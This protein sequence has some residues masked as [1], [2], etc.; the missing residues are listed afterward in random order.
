[1]I[2]E[3]IQQKRKAAGL[4][5]AQLAELL[6][7]S[8]PAV[9]RWE[10]DLSFPDATLLAP[11]ARCLNT[12]LN[13]L[14]SFYDSF[15]DKERELA[16]KK[17]THMLL[18]A[19]YEE[20]FAYV[21]NVLRQN[22]SDGKLHLGIAKTLYGAHLLKKAH[23]PDIY[24]DRITKYYERALELLPDQE[25]EISITLMSIYA[26][27]GDRE[28][29]SSYCEKLQGTILERMEHHSDMLFLLKDYP[30]AA[31]EL[32]GL[33]LRKVVALSTDLGLL[34][35]IL[36]ACND[37]ELA[38]LARDKAGGLRKLFNLWEGFEIL[39]LVSSAVSSLD[40]EAH[41][42]YMQELLLA[43][44]FGKHISECPLFADVQLG[45]M[46]ENDSTTADSMADLMAALG[47]LK[48]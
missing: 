8:P 1:M 16:V 44:P 48:K 40:G 5:Q 33:V 45:G 12:D 6:G 3:M 24:L 4:T 9:N 21:E 25:Q 11:L 32:K 31:E 18:E 14:F 47:N 41:S 26:S 39:S 23:C 15:S 30:A 28:K 7:V 43:D 27:L 17:V 2:G 34:H 42:R 13:E 46:S 35:D 19:D 22:R 10:K 37:I 38:E 29:A 20:T 36:L